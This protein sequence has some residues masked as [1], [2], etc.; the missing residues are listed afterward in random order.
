MRRVIRLTSKSY[1]QWGISR[2]VVLWTVG[3][4]L[5]WE[6]FAWLIADVWQLLAPASKLPYL[7]LVLN[8]AVQYWPVLAEQGAITFGNSLLGFAIGCAVGFLLAVLM[9]LSRTLE[10]T[11]SP[12]MIASQMVPII[13]LA[14]IIYGIVHDPAL[15]R[16]LMS[17][18]VTFFPVALY[19]LR[20]LQSIRLE[21]E[22]LMRSYAASTWTLYLKLKLQAS[23][24]GLFAGLKLSAPLAITASIIVELMG[25]PN[26]IG[27][28]M[29]SSLYYGNAQVYMFWATVLMSIAIGLLL[30]AAISMA[31]RL[32][33]PWQP[34]FRSQGRDE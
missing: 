2:N 20:G 17:G 1:R 32:I 21:Q 24:P 19:T 7:H 11:L 8:A 25:A 23:L 12:Y 4:L 26:G 18:Y 10:H 33:T 30:L 16:T 15:S 3:V 29:I 9:S 22:E 28:L 14:P 13:G 27:V 31:E 5:L 34:E 6:A